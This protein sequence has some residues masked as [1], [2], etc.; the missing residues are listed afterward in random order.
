M[1]GE[2]TGIDENQ[3]GII[4][5]INTDPFY[6]DPYPRMRSWNNGS[7]SGSDLKSK[8][9][10]LFEEQI[11]NKN[12]IWIPDFLFNNKLIVHVYKTKK[13]ISL[14]KNILL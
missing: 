6:F 10:K 4:Q 5:V 8:E 12:R 1:L 3:E 14:K 2:D 11:F 9:F 7:D 13:V